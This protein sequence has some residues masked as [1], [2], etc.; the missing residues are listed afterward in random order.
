LAYIGTFKPI[1]SHWVALADQ[2]LVSGVNFV[3]GIILART[4]GVEIFGT[5]VIAMSFLYYA[6]TFQSSLVIAPMMTAIPHETEETKRQQMLSGFFGFALMLSL[7]TMAGIAFITYALGAM[8]SSLHLGEN[9]WPLL[10]AILGFQSQ[11]WLRRAFYA[12]RKTGWV[13][14]LDLLAYGGQL[15]T[16]SMLYFQHSLTPAATLLSTAGIFFLSTLLIIIPQN[17][18]PSFRHALHVVKTHW[19]ESRD[20]FVSWQLQWASSQGLGLFGG[21]VLGPQVLGALRASTNL[22]APVS[23]LFQWLENI[24]PVRAVAHLKKD[25]LPGMYHFLFRLAWVGTLPFG[26][27]VV[28]LYFFAG[29]LIGFLYGAEYRPYAYFVVLQGVY[30]WLAHYYRLEL[31]ACR[32]TGRITDVASASLIFAIISL[33][34]GVLGVY[35]IGESALIIAPIM[36][37]TVSHLYL[38]YRRKY[39]HLN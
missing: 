8:V 24:I 12:Q 22:V 26:L 9:F 31:F 2:V 4:F 7:L 35:W 30:L 11:D 38:T 39:T 19:R 14:L 37:Q 20:Y 28:G 36:G 10:L 29:P 32:A 27:L 6:N 17:I 16:L 33:S 3:I 21:G 1:P 23:V 18:F 15:A 13:F 5:Y 34:A 25:G